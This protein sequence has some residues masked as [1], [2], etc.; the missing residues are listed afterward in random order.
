MCLA[1]EA[2]ILAHKDHHAVGGFRC[3]AG[4]MPAAF[5]VRARGLKTGG[6]EDVLLAEGFAQGRQGGDDIC[7]VAIC[8]P[9]SHLLSRAVG[10]RT[11]DSDFLCSLER[12]EIVVFE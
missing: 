8:D 2:G 6:K 3:L 10:Q 12:E 11:E 7:C 5:V 1:G 4:G 9:A